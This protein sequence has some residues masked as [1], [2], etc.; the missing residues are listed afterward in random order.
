MQIAAGID[1]RRNCG[2]VFGAPTRGKNMRHL[3]HLAMSIVL[4]ASMVQSAAAQ[5]VFDGGSPNFLQGYGGVNIAQGFSL[6]SSVSFNTVRFWG[7][8]LNSTAPF[9]GSLPWSFYNRNGSSVG[10]VVVSGSTVPVGTAVSGAVTTI[11]AY[12][13]AVG[14]QTLGAGDYFFGLNLNNPPTNRFWM[15]TDAIAP[16]AVTWSNDPS[17]AGIIDRGL[18][19]QLRNTAVPEPSSLALIACGVALIGVHTVRRRRRV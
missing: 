15:A 19:F 17:A 4:S 5:V 2:A 18:A 13:L 10:N 12:D 14:P 1:L 16:V 11:F 6:S 7:F 3:R 8:T 9:S